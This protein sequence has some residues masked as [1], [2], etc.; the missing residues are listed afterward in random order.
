[1]MTLEIE[2]TIASFKR[3]GYTFEGWFHSPY[4]LEPRAGIFV[5][6][7]QGF[8]N[9]FVLDVDESTDIREAVMQHERRSQWRRNALGGLQYA[10][11]YTEDTSSEFLSEFMRQ[12]IV[13]HIRSTEQPVCGGRDVITRS[14]ARL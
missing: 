8:M 4:E 11:I 9:P 5:V 10:V 1:M 12:N 6:A 2:Q 13:H 14:E 3:W 7:T